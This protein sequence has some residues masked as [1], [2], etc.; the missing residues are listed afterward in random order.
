MKSLPTGQE[1]VQKFNTK[2]YC[3]KNDFNATEEFLCGFFLQ[4]YFSSW[5]SCL[6][7]KHL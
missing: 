5:C 3:I 6:N 4:F 7:L 2:S 1:N